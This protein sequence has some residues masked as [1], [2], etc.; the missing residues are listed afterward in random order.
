MSMPKRKRL[1]KEV[2][3][4]HHVDISGGFRGIYGEIM[5]ILNSDQGPGKAMNFGL[6]GDNTRRSHNQVVSREGLKK[7]VVLF[8]PKRFVI[9][10]YEFN[11]E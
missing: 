5:V 11:L 9:T 2:L 10:D 6:D 3:E 1:K 8:H 4:L 7:I